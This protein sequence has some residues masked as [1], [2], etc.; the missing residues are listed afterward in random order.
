MPTFSLS[1]P[2][3]Q[4][5]LCIH[6]LLAHLG[7]QRDSLPGFK[8]YFALTGHKAQGKPLPV[9]CRQYSEFLDQGSLEIQRDK[10]TKHG[11]QSNGNYY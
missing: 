1:F 11:T 8:S 4:A 7:Q 10:E 9:K 3:Y 2:H 5:S 6:S